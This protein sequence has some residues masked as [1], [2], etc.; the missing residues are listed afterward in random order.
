MANLT[1]VWTEASISDEAVLREVARAEG[2]HAARVGADALP[3]TLLAALAQGGVVY[4]AT[5]SHDAN[6]ALGLG[7]DEVVRLE[8]LSR[9][10]LSHALRQATV[11]AEARAT[12]RA[13]EVG[14]RD[15]AAAVL[16]MLAAALG[17]AVNTPLT[18]ASLTSEALSMGLGPMLAVQE[19][20]IGW[21]ALAAPKPELGRLMTTLAEQPTPSQLRVMLSDL[22]EG[23]G[24]AAQVAD[25]L[26]RLSS[27]EAQP[28]RANA[29][30]TIEDVHAFLRS[31]I[32]E[33]AALRVAI[34]GPCIVRVG[35]P[36][37]VLLLAGL[38]AHTIEAVRAPGVDDARITIGVTGHD[39][40]VLIE[41]AHEGRPCPTDLRPSMLQPYF[42]L[43]SDRAGDLTVVG[44]QQRA[45]MLG[46]E[47]LLLHEGRTT[48]LR[49]ALPAVEVE[50]HAG[51]Q[52]VERAPSS[53]NR[54]AD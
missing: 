9:D 52:P 26:G 19:R 11:R 4:V 13:Q 3:T 49:L 29:A 32:G 39:D 24:R 50:L 35:R 16:A 8:H 28:G 42:S 46:G 38:L 7:A 48:T 2:A 51:T 5:G 53:S 17:H 15:D 27:E 6:R 25:L 31:H 20:L 23:I 45:R 40:V 12:R 14:A 30:T 43:A 37:L 33:D 41:I 21:A 54:R 44:L 47:L 10:A 22:R 1:L 34:E 18:I 36:T